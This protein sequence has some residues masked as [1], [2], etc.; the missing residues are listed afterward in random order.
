MSDFVDI[1]QYNVFNTYIF[2]NTLYK[3]N[4]NKQSS[5]FVLYIMRKFEFL[6]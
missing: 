3:V 1:H 4:F 5:H 2:I 6:F